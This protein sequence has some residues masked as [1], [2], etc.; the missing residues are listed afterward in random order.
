MLKEAQM[1]NHQILH[2]QK[3]RRKKTVYF[4]YRLIYIFL[5]AQLM[6]VFFIAKMLLNYFYLVYLFH[7]SILSHAIIL[8]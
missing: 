4:Y 5:N 8:L 1:K 3:E 2:V 7:K 6:N